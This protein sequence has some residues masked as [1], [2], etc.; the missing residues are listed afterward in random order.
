MRDS[1]F[2]VTRSALAL[3]PGRLNVKRLI[4]DEINN[5][6]ERLQSGRS[7]EFIALLPGMEMELSR[8]DQ[9]IRSMPFV[10]QVQSN[11]VQNG[12][13]HDEHEV[14]TETR[15]I[16]A[17]SQN[18]I[19][20]SDLPVVIKTKT[21]H[22]TAAGVL[23]QEL[24]KGPLNSTDFLKRHKNDT[25]LTWSSLKTLRQNVMKLRKAGL[26]IVNK[27]GEGYTLRTQVTGITPD[28]PALA[29]IE[30]ITE[31]IPALSAR[32]TVIAAFRANHIVNLTEMAEKHGKSSK[33]YYMWAA[34]KLR[35][36]GWKFKR[37]DV[38]V[39]QLIK[40]GK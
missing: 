25:D 38:G 31:P 28:I 24:I 34:H 22:V 9:S 8:L 13:Q 23:L 15:Q 19:D 5:I 16:A 30:S 11:G 1:T 2:D 33:F 37:V 7:A 35:K 27:S 12:V 17:S 4:E 39:F 6:K 29:T 3:L 21:G 40:E 36:L 10:G 26:D 18:T 32:D 20:V 14:K